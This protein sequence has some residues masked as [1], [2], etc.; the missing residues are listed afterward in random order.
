MSPA[1]IH[2]GDEKCSCD[3]RWLNL[4]FQ[5]FNS[6][7]LLRIRYFDIASAWKDR[8]THHGSRERVLVVF[9]ARRNELNRPRGLSSTTTWCGRKRPRGLPKTWTSAPRLVGLRN[10][11]FFHGFVHGF[12]CTISSWT[13]SAE[14]QRSRGAAASAFFLQT[15]MKIIPSPLYLII[16]IP[17]KP[18]WNAGAEATY[19]GP[20]NGGV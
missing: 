8:Y 12:L 20:W 5:S 1:Q 9:I 4:H 7:N 17:Q 3:V 10:R 2:P 13:E 11:R 15:Q 16:N 18:W 14:V 6:F 19:L